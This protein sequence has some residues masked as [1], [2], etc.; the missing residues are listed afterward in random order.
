MIGGRQSDS[1]KI[2]PTATSR[3]FRRRRIKSEYFAILPRGRR[4]GVIGSAAVRRKDL[5]RMQ[6][7]SSAPIEE[8]N[9]FASAAQV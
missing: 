2:P 4:A 3:A 1:S 5:L 8:A 6:G 9:D 7:P